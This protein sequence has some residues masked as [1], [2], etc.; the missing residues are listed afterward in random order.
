MFPVV[1][2]IG[3]AIYMALG[4][5]HMR[6]REPQVYHT[7]RISY[8]GVPLQAQGLGQLPQS[9]PQRLPLIVMK[10]V[11]I[12]KTTW[13]IFILPDCYKFINTQVCIIELFLTSFTTVY[14]TAWIH[15]IISALLLRSPRFNLH[16]VADHTLLAVEVKQRVLLVNTEVVG[17]DEISEGKYV[18]TPAALCWYW[19]VSACSPR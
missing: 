9:P 1:I 11:A 16:V 12:T 10:V 8:R 13:Q 7:T 3:I 5:C 14:H 19:P 15:N 4:E 6:G 2:S 17:D 18:M